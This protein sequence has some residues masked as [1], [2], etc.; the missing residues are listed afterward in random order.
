MTR[1]ASFLFL[2]LIY[3]FSCI[4]IAQTNQ[5]LT[6]PET[7]ANTPDNTQGLSTYTNTSENTN[8]YLDDETKFQEQ[9]NST[10]DVPTIPENTPLI[11]TD[12]IQPEG[13]NDTQAGTEALNSSSDPK[14]F[15]NQVLLRGLNKITARTSTIKVV[16]GESVKF[17]NLNITLH[18]CWKSP[19]EE[20]QESKALLEVWEE[21][22][23]E[24]RKKIFSG[25]MF[26]SSP[27]ISAP[28]HPVYDITVLECK[29]SLSN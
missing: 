16:V 11:K 8:N 24:P 22:P 28:E 27:L 6:T 23:K 12:I 2:L 3:S 7:L 18:S 25:W 26:A 15:T 4:A 10:A 1:A 20:D 9:Q 14:N 5:E 29:D 17:G 21:I 13:K 19:P